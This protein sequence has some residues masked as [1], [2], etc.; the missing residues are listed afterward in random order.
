[1]SRAVTTRSDQNRAYKLR[2][3]S[4]LTDLEAAW[5]RRHD[6]AVQRERGSR[7]KPGPPRQMVDRLIQIVAARY[8]VRP[9]DLTRRGRGGTSAQAARSVL[10]VALCQAGGSCEAIAKILH[11]TPSAVS[12]ISRRSSCRPNLEAEVAA[13]LDDVRVPGAGDVITLRVVVGSRLWRAL[14]GF[15][16]AFE[17]TDGAIGRGPRS[18]LQALGVGAD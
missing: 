2:K 15:E 3:K 1:M 12:Q 4:E 7:K 18:E 8:S 17:L 14:D 10:V 9:A 6:A 11:R 16:E 5:L 13:V